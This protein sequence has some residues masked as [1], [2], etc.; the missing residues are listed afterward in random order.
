MYMD[1]RDYS[2]WHKFKKRN[3]GFNVV[4]IQIKLFHKM[5]KSKSYKI[6]IYYTALKYSH[7]HSDP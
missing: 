6:N 4:S 7:L 5:K 2:T 1:M 3:S